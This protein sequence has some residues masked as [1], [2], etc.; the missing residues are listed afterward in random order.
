MRRQQRNEAQRSWK[1]TAGLQPQSKRLLGH[2]DTC[3]LQWDTCGV[4]G[5]H[6]QDTPHAHGCSLDPDPLRRQP[7]LGGG[8][9][10]SSTKAARIHACGA[11][12]VSLPQAVAPCGQMEG[13]IQTPGQ[14]LP[15]PLAPPPHL[16]VGG[17]TWLP[18]TVHLHRP[19]FMTVRDSK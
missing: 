5:H 12:E 8:T 17:A 1:K 15:T 14:G 3:V 6:E 7:V 13:V 10:A 19:L 2:I 9:G 16:G 4:P 11:E 18:P